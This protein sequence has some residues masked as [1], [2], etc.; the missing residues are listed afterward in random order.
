[1]LCPI[2]R[3]EGITAEWSHLLLRQTQTTALCSAFDHFALHM[4]SSSEYSSAKNIL[5]LNSRSFPNSLKRLA[6]GQVRPQ[7]RGDAWILNYSWTQWTWGEPVGP[8]P[9]S[10]PEVIARESE[11]DREHHLFNVNWEGALSL[12]K[13]CSSLR[14]ALGLWKKSSIP[15]NLSFCRLSFDIGFVKF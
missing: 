2:F 15:L 6:F 12:T 10:H 11:P 13:R 5:Q 1:M 4:R 8:G 3:S 14:A 7:L 9:R